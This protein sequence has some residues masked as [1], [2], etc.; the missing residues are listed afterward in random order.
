MASLGSP[1][2]KLSLLQ[3]GAFFTTSV[4]KHQRRCLEGD[5][6]S[7]FGD[8]Q[9]S[10]RSPEQPAQLDRLRAGGWVGYH[11]RCSNMRD[12][13]TRLGSF[14]SSQTKLVSR[15]NGPWASDRVLHRLSSALRS[16]W[17]QRPLLMGTALQSSSR[18]FRKGK[19]AVKPP[20]RQ[21]K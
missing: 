7:V 13:E 9:N 18:V 15:F 14:C 5:E 17:Y 6:F 10:Q 11:Q 2:H 20:K 8:T 21:E 12:L 4:I 16:H 1:R 19:V 3:G